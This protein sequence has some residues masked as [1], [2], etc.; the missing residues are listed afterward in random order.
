MSLALDT[1][2]AGWNSPKAVFKIIILGWIL[3]IIAAASSFIERCYHWQK[4]VLIF[5]VLAGMMVDLS[6]NA[7]SLYEP[8]LTVRR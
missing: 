6:L 5:L 1:T 8:Y 4:A 3:L 7:I 2:Y